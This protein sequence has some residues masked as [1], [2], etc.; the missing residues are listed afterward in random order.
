MQELDITADDVPTVD[1]S[2]SDYR[3]TTAEIFYHLPDYPD[4]VQTYVWQELDR[5][6]DFPK[7]HDFLGLWE[8]EIDGKL[9]S[10]RVAYVDIIRPGEWLDT[11]TGNDIPV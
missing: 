7:L 3:L 1:S 11:S 8:R 4:M 9:H 2:L 10:I 5:L 6:P